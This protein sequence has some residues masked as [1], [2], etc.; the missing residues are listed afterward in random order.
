M[1]FD[2]LEG[3][4]KKWLHLGHD[5]LILRLLY[6]C[7]L[8]NRYDGNPIW[9][10]VVGPSGS[11][12]TALLSS[13][14]DSPEIKYV[15]NMTPYSLAS[16][17]G[18]PK[19]SLLFEL[20][21][22]ILVVEDMSSVS[23]MPNEARSLLYSFLRSAY[24]GEFIRVTGKNQIAWRGKFGM[25]AGSTLAIEMGRRMET[26]LGERF[27]YLRMRVNDEQEKA[28]ML[29][30]RGHTGSKSVMRDDLEKAAG[31]FL[32]GVVI[33]PMQRSISKEIIEMIDNC[34]CIL[35][36]SRSTVQRDTFTKEITFPVES[37]ELGTRLFTQLTLIALAARAMGTAWDVVKRMVYRVTLDSMPY[38]R[39]RILQ[40]IHRGNVSN[41]QVTEDLRM[42]HQSVQRTLDEMVH[43]GVL[44]RN[45]KKEY[46][47]DSEVLAEA[48]DVI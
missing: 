47:V 39:L 30:T 22:K 28:I 21:D 11:G 2:D 6:A 3:I 40:A 8:A 16:G 34:A 14:R 48:L 26:S 41:D 12:K 5:D 25:L 42:G 4:Y 23:E 9:T 13:L 36:K 7:V 19:D 31:V 45:R 20:N 44:S 27:L 32:A 37:G 18:D 15:S 29:A 10:M 1:N 35:A 24:N 46:E 17:S 43:L 38:I 33:D